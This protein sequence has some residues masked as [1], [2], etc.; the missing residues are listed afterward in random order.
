MV[1]NARLNCESN[2]LS[3]GRFHRFSLVP[4]IA[5]AI[6]IANTS[7]SMSKHERNEFIRIPAG[8]P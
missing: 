5:I 3:T 7:T 4:A 8:M 2:Q 6:G 1:T